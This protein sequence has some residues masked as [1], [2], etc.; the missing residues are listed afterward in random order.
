MIKKDEYSIETYPDLY[1]KIKQLIDS[2][3]EVVA[4]EP[5]VTKLKE[6]PIKEWLRYL[7]DDVYYDLINKAHLMINYKEI[8]ELYDDFKNSKNYK[9]RKLVLNTKILSEEII[10]IYVDL[11]F[12]LTYLKTHCS[13]N[14]DLNRDEIK[15]MRFFKDF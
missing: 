5:E 3:G 9:L 15:N 12:K 1:K 7:S 14:K 10:D 13:P 11:D 2:L 8:N 4:C 6:H